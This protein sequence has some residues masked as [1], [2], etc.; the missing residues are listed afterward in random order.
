[1]NNNNTTAV[2][3]GPFTWYP[4]LWSW[5]LYSQVTIAGIGII[6]N[7]VTVFVYT[8]RLSR[9]TNMDKLIRSLAIADLCSSINLLPYPDAVSTPDGL[10]GFVYCK[11]IYLRCALWISLVASIF[12]LTAMTIEQCVSILFPLKYRFVFP[13]NRS[14]WVIL[15][16]W[17]ASGTINVVYNLVITFRDSETG[18]CLT[19]FGGD[20]FEAI[21]GTIIF[22]LEY[23]LPVVIM[24]TAHSMT[25]RCLRKQEGAIFRNRSESKGVVQRELAVVRARKKIFKMVLFVIITFISTWS[26][27]QMAFLLHGWKVI[28]YYNFIYQ[29]SVPLALI[30]SCANPFIYAATN[31]H[32][33]KA[34]CNSN[35]WKR[36]GSTSK[37]GNATSEGNSSFASRDTSMVTSR[38]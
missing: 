30:N 25:L 19:D 33:R 6:G 36:E 13:K 26:I 17:V 28:N 34:L 38:I 3:D 9:L 24:V 18:V 4:L 23:F 7:S 12:I 22:V 37:A 20:F 5:L 8:W 27:D 31:P 14:G 21:I 1:M 16:V 32:F 35:L 11:V 10:I 29:V 2:Y 15:G